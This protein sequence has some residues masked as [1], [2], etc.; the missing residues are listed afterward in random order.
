[1]KDERYKIS[2]EDFNKLKDKL[3]YILSK[4]EATYKDNNGN[5]EFDYASY[6]RKIHPYIKAF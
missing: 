5:I 4:S 6:G 3:N 2:I 1:M